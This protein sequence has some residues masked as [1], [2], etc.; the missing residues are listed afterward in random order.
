VRPIQATTLTDRFHLLEA[1]LTARVN[2]RPAV[3]PG[4]AG[5]WQQVVDSHGDLGMQALDELTGWSH[6]SAAT[7][8]D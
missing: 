3:D 2:D 1:A 7:D 6:H 8:A 5:A 4:L